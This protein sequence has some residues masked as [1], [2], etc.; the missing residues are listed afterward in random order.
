[1]ASEKKLNTMQIYRTI[2]AA[3]DFGESTE[4]VISHAVSLANQNEALLKVLHV[5]EYTFPMDE[6]FVIPPVNEIT[7]QLVDEAKRRLDAMMS[8]MKDVCS[9][10][11]IL[12]GHPKQEIVRFVEQEQAD[13][14]VIGAH[15]HHGIAGIL[16]ST[17]DRVV[18][19]AGCDVLVI[20]QRKDIGG[21]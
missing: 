16:G 9:E 12:T 19:R 7:D 11:T 6:D 4:S 13:L 20:R 15:G 3:V 10:R 1:M 5:V 21:G 14:I 2:I 18:H 8:P 17:T